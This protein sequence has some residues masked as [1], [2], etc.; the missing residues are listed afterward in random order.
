MIAASGKA[1]A[2]GRAGPKILSA[3]ATRRLTWVAGALA[4]AFSAILFV[5]ALQ[6]AAGVDRHARDE[7]QTRFVGAVALYGGAYG[8]EDRD[9]LALA[10]IVG[11]E[12]AAL[13]DAPNTERAALTLDD[14]RHMSWSPDRPGAVLFAQFAPIRIPL[15]MATML[16]LF[17]IVACFY[18]VAGQLECERRIAERL[19]AVDPLT[20]LGNRL[21][22]DRALAELAATPSRP[23]ALLCLDLDGFKAI[24]DGFGH[25][26]G[27]AVL[28]ELGIR[29]RDIFGDAFAVSR[30]GGDEFCVLLPGA[31]DAEL[32]AIARD[33]RLVLRRPYAIAGRRL[34]VGVSIG[35]AARPN[36]GQTPQGLQSLADAALYR[37]KAARTGICLAGT[38][39]TPVALEANPASA[40]A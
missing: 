34:E 2:E 26:A 10:R 15:A 27:D 21:A 35:I 22:F 3:K 18:R 38:R 1:P 20:G 7:E 24:N 12:D 25:A 29:L 40:A 8:F 5:T 32:M 17:A 37:A 6:I 19:A 39:L 33:A 13:G 28:V 36:H 30:L 16:L 11:L 4:L 23:V 31:A 9:L 14:G